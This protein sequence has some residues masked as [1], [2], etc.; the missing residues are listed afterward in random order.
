MKF[1]GTIFIDGKGQST[2]VYY[3]G[4]MMRPSYREGH[5]DDKRQIII[6]NVESTGEDSFE[7]D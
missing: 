1:T 2:G 4:C 3:P 7:N 6:K 5:M